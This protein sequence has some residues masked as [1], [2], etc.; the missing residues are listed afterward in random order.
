MSEIIKL[1]HGSERIISKPLYNYGKKDNDY[2]R[3]FYCTKEIEKAK[4]WACQKDRDGFVNSYFL[5]TS[6]LKI[7]NLNTKDYSVLHWLSIL[8]QNRDVDN[9]DNSEAVDFLKK[10]YSIDTSKYDVIIGYRADDSFFTFARD[11]IND[12]ITIQSLTKA[13]KLGKL[14]L[15]VMIKSKT[16]FDNLKY[17]GSEPV[18]KSIYYSKYKT[19]DIDA[20]VSYNQLRKEP[21]SNGL[22]IT[23][24][25][26]NPQLLQEF[27]QNLSKD[28]ITVLP[29]EELGKKYMDVLLEATKT[30]SLNESKTKAFETVIKSSDKITTS[31]NKQ[32]L[33]SFFKKE[34]INTDNDFDEYIKRNQKSSPT[35]KRK[36]DDDIGCGF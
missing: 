23:E 13:M 9:L 18:L 25:I 22:I 21:K 34:G 11:F 36:G 5:D 19:R 35:P 4:E 30:L 16:A 17:I 3:G 12:A 32:N 27:E 15:Q 1:F 29:F 20:R 33:K 28:S 6:G 7:L 8:V 2:G 31:I 10:N 26:K 24:I 14:G